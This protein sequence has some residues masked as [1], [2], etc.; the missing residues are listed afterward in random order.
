MHSRLEPVLS[1]DGDPFI[2]GEKGICGP[3]VIRCGE[4]KVCGLTDGGEDVE[5]GKGGEDEDKDDCFYGG[6]RSTRCEGPRD[7]THCFKDRVRTVRNA[8]DQS[9]RLLV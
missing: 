4:S 5:I 3:E 2:I 6:K 7:S 8:G 1:G 9:A